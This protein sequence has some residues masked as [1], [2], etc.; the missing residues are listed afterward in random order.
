MTQVRLPAIL[1][2]LAASARADA[3]LPPPEAIEQCSANGAHCATA[4]PV[5]N[6]IDVYRK[7]TPGTPLWSVPGWARVFHVSDSG[8]HLVTCFGGVN[9]LPLDYKRD[10][11]M[12][13]FYDR[14]RLV[15]SV[16]L[17]ELVP[18]LTKLRRTV[19]HYEWGR[20]VGFDGPATYSVETV[21]RGLLRFDA[22]TGQLAK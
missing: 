16:T 19:S 6:R 17:A 15:R 3:P 8:R 10:E 1:T 7:G 13:T 18:D 5:A 21:D 9:L 11:P 4:D 2:L 14:G 20:C 22:T 12:L